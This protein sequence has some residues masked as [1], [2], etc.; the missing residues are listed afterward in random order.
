MSAAR[1][2]PVEE[3]SSQ[4]TKASPIRPKIVIMVGKNRQRHSREYE[5][6]LRSNEHYLSSNEK[7]AW[8]KFRP[9]RDLNPWPLRYRL[10]ALHYC[11]DRFHIHI[12]NRSSSVWLPYIHN[13]HQSRWWEEYSQHS[14]ARQPPRVWTV[15]Y[16]C[17]R[18]STS[19]TTEFM[20]IHDFDSLQPKHLLWRPNGK[21]IETIQDLWCALEVKSDAKWNTKLLEPDNRG[22][23]L[24]N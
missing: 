24:R 16:H 2:F 5:S 19:R 7:K 10:T 13:Q 6:D 12:F 11:E 17:D 3:S 8:I 23:V 22:C 18:Y 9:V 20:R 15:C 21:K 4:R 1:W 14:L